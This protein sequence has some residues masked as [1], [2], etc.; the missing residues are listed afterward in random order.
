MLKTIGVVVV[1]MVNLSAPMIMT[2]TIMVVTVPVNTKVSEDSSMYY[3]LQYT[4][5]NLLVM[6]ASFSSTNKTQHA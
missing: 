6:Q 1:T 2:M 4:Y 3:S 5:Y